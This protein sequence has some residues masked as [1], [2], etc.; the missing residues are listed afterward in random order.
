M[1]FITMTGCLYL[2]VSTPFRMMLPERFRE[3][4]ILN[5]SYSLW[6]F[7]SVLIL[8]SVFTRPKIKSTYPVLLF[9]WYSAIIFF[10]IIKWWDFLKRHHLQRYLKG[11]GVGKIDCQLPNQKSAAPSHVTKRLS[12]IHDLTE[13]ICVLS[14]MLSFRLLWYLY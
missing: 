9:F 1:V 12:A 7:G 4:N 6:C 3:F 11:N 10:R 8:N 5:T 2:D 14:Q 13:D